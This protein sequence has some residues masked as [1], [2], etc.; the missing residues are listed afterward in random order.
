MRGNATYRA[1]AS[2]EDYCRA[3][4]IDRIHT[5]VAVDE[6]GRPARGA[7]GAEPHADVHP[8]VAQV[9]GVGVPLTAV[10]NDGD[11]LPLERRQARVAVVVDVHD[12]ARSL[13]SA[14]R[15]SVPRN[16]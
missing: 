3:C 2:I 13:P 1:G 12:A 4:K 16:I 14:V 8:A 9:E 6:D 5:V 11:L 15:T 10:A 7:V